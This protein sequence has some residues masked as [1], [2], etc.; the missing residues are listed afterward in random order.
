MRTVFISERTNK[1][2]RRKKSKSC[3]SKKRQPKLQQAT[4]NVR[5][6]CDILGSLLRTFPDED[7]LETQIF[8]LEY[9]YLIKYKL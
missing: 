3:H 4:N 1:P 8:I 2:R 5:S 9:I 6:F 7:L